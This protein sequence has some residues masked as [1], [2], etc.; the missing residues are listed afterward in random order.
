MAMPT[1]RCFSLMRMFWL[2]AM[3]VTV[4]AAAN[5]VNMNHNDSSIPAGPAFTLN[6]RKIFLDV[7]SGGSSTVGYQGPP[8]PTLVLGA[9]LPRTGTASL[10]KALSMLGLNCYHMMVAHETAGH[11][12]MWRQHLSLQTISVDE[13]MDG[14]A[15]AGFNA[16]IDAPSAFHYKEQLRR[17]PQAKVILTERS[18]QQ[19]LAAEHWAESVSTT[20]LRIPLITREVPWSWMGFAVRYGQ[21]QDSMYERVKLPH[22]IDDFPR[23]P[24]FYKQW[25]A[26]VKDSVPKQNLLVFRAQDGWKPLCDFLSPVADIVESNCRIIMAAGVEYPYENDKTKIIACSA[27][28]LTITRIVKAIPAVAVPV[29]VAII[30]MWLRLLK[31]QRISHGVSEKGRIE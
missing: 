25:N 28:F 5:E 10:R 2:F 11:L 6:A 8:Q 18:E 3:M 1:S 20:I 16:T 31:R 26:E 30:A 12:E 14:L 27:V 19:D 13:V 29:A 21:F 7:M 17:Y 15:M 24:T 4:R 22:E 23:L 9:G